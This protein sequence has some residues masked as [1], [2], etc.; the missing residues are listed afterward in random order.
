MIVKNL[1]SQKDFCFWNTIMAIRLIS[2]KHACSLALS[3]VVFINLYWKDDCF[4][5]T[6]TGGF[7][8]HKS[9]SLQ[10]SCWG[11]LPRSGRDADIGSYYPVSEKVS[12]RKYLLKVA[13]TVQ[14]LARPGWPL[15]EDGNE[16]DST[17]ASF[18]SSWK[19]W[20]KDRADTAA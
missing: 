3:K 10:S 6:K 14:Y 7:C 11:D 9:S 19:S 13:Q 4:G 20:F 1:N 18:S 16:T 15:K 2:M 5:T 8:K 17:F 12:N